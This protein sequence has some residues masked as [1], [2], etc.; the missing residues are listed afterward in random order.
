M[1]FIL[2]TRFHK[3]KRVGKAYLISPIT[4][5]AARERMTGSW[6]RRG[7]YCGNGSCNSGNM[8]YIIDS[9]AIGCAGRCVSRIKVERP[10]H[11]R[12]LFRTISPGYRCEIGRVQRGRN[13][14]R[15]WRKY[16]PDYCALPVTGACTAR[17]HV[18][19]KVIQ[20]LSLRI[21]QD[22]SQRCIDNPDCARSLSGRKRCRLQRGLG[23]W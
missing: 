15:G 10:S 4:P 3:V 11:V 18:I 22:F 17:T 5:A 19:C 9:L 21:C 7:G 12:G 2:F 20:G 6:Y 8:P 13:A 23:C 16:R 14:D 1:V